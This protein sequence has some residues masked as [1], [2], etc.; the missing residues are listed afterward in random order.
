MKSSPAA[1]VDAN[2]LRSAL[3]AG[4][5]AGSAITNGERLPNWR[6]SDRETR[7]DWFMVKSL[8]I[9]FTMM[10][11]AKYRGAAPRVPRWHKRRF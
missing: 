5:G 11:N 2:S 8:K 7:R 4:A 9:V 6:G 10:T 1:K 3:K